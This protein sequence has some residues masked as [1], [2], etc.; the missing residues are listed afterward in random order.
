[1]LLEKKIRRGDE[2]IDNLP[3]D[4]TCGK[5]FDRLILGEGDQIQFDARVVPYVKGYLGR[6]EYVFSKIELDLGLE[7]PTKAFK[8][9]RDVAA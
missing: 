2:Y 6:R 4:F 7:R 8:I 1:I 3:L 5:T 9:L